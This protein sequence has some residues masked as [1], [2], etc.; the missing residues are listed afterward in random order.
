[1]GALCC[2][3]IPEDYWEEYGHPN[4]LQNCFGVRYC[5]RW[6]IRAY[7][8]LIDPQNEHR[9]GGSP[10]HGTSASPSAVLLSPTRTDST[11]PD[12]Y[13]APP[14]P[15]PFDHR[16]LRPRGPTG[17]GGSDRQQEGGEGMALLRR[18]VEVGSVTAP[19]KAEE[20]ETEE[21]KK[22][23]NIKRN[24]SVMSFTDEE[25]CPTC[26]DGYTE[27]NPKIQTACLHHFHLSCIYEWME[28]SNRCPVCDK[29]MM[30]DER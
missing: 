6:C 24:T 16:N 29:E 17:K 14:M 26:L 3:P 4:S 18:G 27:D 21:T 22:M 10:I 20:T 11:N 7:R 23:A 12:S 1:M 9:L 13:R 30:F 19:P 5:F 15:L 2:C 25:C 8:T 28:R